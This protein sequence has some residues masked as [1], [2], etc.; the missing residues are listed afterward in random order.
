MHVIDADH[1]DLPTNAILPTLRD[2]SE[3]Q[4][5]IVISL[6]GIFAKGTRLRKKPRNGRNAIG[7]EQGEFESL[8]YIP[9]EFKRAEQIYNPFIIYRRIQLCNLF[10]P[11]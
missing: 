11:T 4:L 1:R 9:R 8:F 2:L 3:Q 6:L 7:S 10:R 5:C